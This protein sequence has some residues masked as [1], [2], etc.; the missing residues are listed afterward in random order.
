MSRVNSMRKK[1]TKQNPS[2]ETAPTERE[3]VGPE[4]TFASR[5]RSAIAERELSAASLARKIQ[6]DVPEFSPGNISHY[7]A[8]RSLPRPRVLKAISRVLETDLSAYA[9]SDRRGGSPARRSIKVS[10]LPL[11]E[12]GGLPALNVKDLGDGEA[13]LQ[14]NQRL[15]W[16]LALK[17]LHAI[18]GSEEGDA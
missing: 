3:E 11:P 9:A 14:V 7:L 16:P 10:A 5:L 17:I 18:R 4:E 13:L 8:G 2:I 15:P 6:D 12:T 1:Q